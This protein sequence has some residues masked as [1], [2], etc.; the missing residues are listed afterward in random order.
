MSWA[1]QARLV[2]VVRGRLVQVKNAAPLLSRPIE[3][4]KRAFEAVG[5]IGEN[6][7]GLE[8]VRRASSSG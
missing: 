3:M 6:F 2:R 5:G 1:S 8:R 4:W 7:G